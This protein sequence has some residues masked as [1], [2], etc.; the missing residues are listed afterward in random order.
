MAHPL[1]ADPKFTKSSL[2]FCLSL[3]NIDGNIKTEKNANC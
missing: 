2:E 3:K 1:V